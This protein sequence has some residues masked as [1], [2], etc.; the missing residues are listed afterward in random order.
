MSYSP[1]TGLAYIPVQQVGALFSRDPADQNDEAVNI[2][3]LVVKPLVKKPGDGKGKLVA[4]D[5]VAQREAWSVQHD[6]LW[7]GGTLAT[8]GGLVFQ[9]TADGLFHAYDAASGSELWKF[10]AGLGIIAAPMSFSA[11]G[12]QYVAVLVGWGGTVAAMSGV[13]DV[14]WKYGQQPRRL[15]VFALDGKAKLA[16]SPPRSM[17]VNAL[18]DPALK[19]KIADAMLGKGMS[20]ACMSC[21]GAG[22]RGAG[23]P[24]PDLRESVIA[25]NLADFS[26][27]IKQGNYA[28]GMPAFPWLSDAQIKG[29][30]AYLRHR[31]REALGKAQPLPP[32]P[33]QPGAGEKP[34]RPVAY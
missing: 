11:G 4:W 31:A 22:F 15:L 12:K 20:I 9:G 2:M 26:A 34:K 1:R 28:R 3:G 18:D 33:A 16:P 25:L 30:H 23:A 24:G 6:N 19:I 32:M 10:D 21:H 8:A 17:T 29:L 7:N 5:P 14:G 27:F 13:M